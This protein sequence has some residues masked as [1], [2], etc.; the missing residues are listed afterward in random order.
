MSTTTI[1]LPA[2]LKDR[3]AQV[4]KRSGSTSHALILDAIAERVEAEERRNEFHEL[5]E[6]RFAEIA[7]SGNTIPWDEMKTYLQRRVAGQ[8]VKRPKP[9]KLAR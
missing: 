3:L 5:A 6:K 2:E 4:A 8:S 9:G 1:R 7:K